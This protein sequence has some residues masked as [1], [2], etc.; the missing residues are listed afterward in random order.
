MPWRKHVFLAGALHRLD[1]KGICCEVTSTGCAQLRKHIQ[2]GHQAPRCQYELETAG[3]EVTGS[4]RPRPVGI[5]TKLVCVSPVCFPAD[6]RQNAGLKNL[7]A[8]LITAGFYK[9][10]MHTPLDKKKAKE[11]GWSNLY[12]CPMILGTGTHCQDVCRVT[13][14]GL[15]ALTCPGPSVPCSSSRNNRA[16]FR[17]TQIFATTSKNMHLL[18]RPSYVRYPNPR[19]ATFPLSP[20]HSPPLSTQEL[21]FCQV[22]HPTLLREACISSAVDIATYCAGLGRVKV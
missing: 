11:S 4:R 21:C 22:C 16:P 10:L 18:H 13:V 12:H 17:A 8:S 3:A 19:L 9:I 2:V 5:L 6:Q 20:T 1:L 7:A 15:H 14:A